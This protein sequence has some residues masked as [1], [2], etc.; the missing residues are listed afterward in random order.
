MAQAVSKT[1]KK[2]MVISLFVVAFLIFIGVQCAPRGMEILRDLSASQTLEFDTVD[3]YKIELNPETKVPEK[4]SGGCFRSA[5]CVQEITTKTNK[6]TVVVLVRI[7]FC[8]E[9]QT[10]NFSYPLKLGDDIQ[11]LR[12][13]KKETLFWS[14]SKGVVK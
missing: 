5:Y 10:G 9:G 4:I 14:R 12:F 6:A 2:R 11:E 13:G 8:K 7:G 3:H 1:R